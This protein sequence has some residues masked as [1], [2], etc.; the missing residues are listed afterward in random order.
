M[1]AAEWLIVGFM[2]AMV[3]LLVYG[4]IRIKKQDR[5]RKEKEEA[6]RKVEEIMKR[7]QGQWGG[8]ENQ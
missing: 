2:L 4:N 3:A 8:H 6:E 5:R 7:N 1:S